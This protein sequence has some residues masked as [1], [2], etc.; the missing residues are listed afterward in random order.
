MFTIGI[1]N[2]FVP[3]PFQVRKQRALQNTIFFNSL[4]DAYQLEAVH[5]VASKSKKKASSENFPLIRKNNLW[6]DIEWVLQLIVRYYDISIE[7][8]CRKLIVV[9]KLDE[10][11]LVNMEKYERVSITLMNRA[12]DPN[13]DKESDK[14]F[15][16][17]FEDHLFLL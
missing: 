1:K 6:Y 11:E 13:L 8:G 14:Y 5:E 16:V 9:L 2:I 12:L 7:E 4:G 15:Q 10:M 3:R 17:Q